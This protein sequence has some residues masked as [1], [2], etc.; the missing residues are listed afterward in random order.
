MS[1]AT[2]RHT[3]HS[4]PY[5]TYNFGP[6]HES[7]QGEGWF[8]WRHAHYED[9]RRQS[10]FLCD[11]E[12][13]IVAHALEPFSRDLGGMITTF[14]V[15]GQGRSVSAANALITLWLTAGQEKSPDELA[16]AYGACLQIAI[17]GFAPSDD[18][19]VRARFRDHFLRQLAA[20]YRRLPPSWLRDAI[21]KIKE[22][23]ESAS[24]EGPELVRMANEI[25]P[26]LMAEDPPRPS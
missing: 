18:V 9:I 14:H 1:E 19:D 13:D 20:N 17:I 22:A 7:R 12:D 4:D 21:E 2:E 15:P 5:W 24:D 23:G 10:H 3:T 11:T 26:E 6:G 25:L 8:A 16:V